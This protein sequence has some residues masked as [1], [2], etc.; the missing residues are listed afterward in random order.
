MHPAAR[1]LAA[2]DAAFARLLADAPDCE[3]GRPFHESDLETLVFAVIGQ[4]ISAKAADAITL[5]LL[6]RTGRV[7][8]GRV[9]FEGRD[10]L[11]LAD[12]EMRA[13][14]CC[15]IAMV[16]QEP[17]TSLNPVLTV[18]FQIMEPMLIHLGMTETAAHARARPRPFLSG[19]L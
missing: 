1:H 9:L 13:L 7:T 12:E 5:R 3:L 16:F 2:N 4:Q 14:R 8:A 15:K 17:M 10:L 19:R 18:G 6:A 11:T